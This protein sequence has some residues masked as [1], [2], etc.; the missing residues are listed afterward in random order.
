MKVPPR[1]GASWF[2][3]REDPNDERRN[4]QSAWQSGN[5]EENQVRKRKNTLFVGA[6]H[7]MSSTSCPPSPILR[8]R[9]DD[10]RVMTWRW[11][12][13][14]HIWISLEP[15]PPPSSAEFGP[16]VSSRGKEGTWSSPPGSPCQRVWATAF[17]GPS[18]M[19]S[20][21]NTCP[22][23]VNVSG[24]IAVGRCCGDGAFSG[25]RSTF[26]FFTN[27]NGADPNA[28]RL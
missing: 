18:N 26:V 24:T 4:F 23:S 1:R 10:L 6:T 11:L 15:S 27:S 16:P 9:V 14:T 2:G 12:S 21:P 17:N 20:T 25:S 13:F 7:C 8:S 3:L 28:W 5:W 19:Q 22:L